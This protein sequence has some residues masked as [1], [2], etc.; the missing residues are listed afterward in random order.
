[1]LEKRWK[2]LE[3][4]AREELE[5]L[6]RAEG[7]DMKDLLVRRGGVSGREQSGKS[8]KKSKK[9]AR[10]A[11]KHTSHPNYMCDHCK[12]K[13]CI[14]GVRYSCKVGAGVVCE[15]QEC[16]DYD[17]CEACFAHAAEFHPHRH[18]LAFDPPQPDVFGILREGK[19][20][21]VEV[22]EVKKEEK[23]EEENDEKEE[24]KKE[25]EEKEEKVEEKKEEMKEEKEEK[26]EED[27]SW[28]VVGEKKR[29][30]RSASVSEGKKER[31][32]EAKPA[33]KLDYRKA[34]LGSLP[35]KPAD[36]APSQPAQPAQPAQ[37]SQPAQPAQP[38]S[39]Q[40]SQPSQQSSQPAQQPSQPQQ[41]PQQPQQQ[42]QQPQQDETSPLAPLPLNSPAFEYGPVMEPNLPL[43]GAF[44]GLVMNPPENLGIDRFYD[45]PDDHMN[46][47][48][49]MEDQWWPK[50][51][52]GMWRQRKV[53][54]ERDP[55]LFEHNGGWNDYFENENQPM[56][57]RVPYTSEELQVS[58]LLGREG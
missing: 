48:A 49:N 45:Y 57:A 17:L 32:R 37:P 15:A 23:G 5:E 35:T 41:Q 4:N 43:G 52:Y 25:K 18:F 30:N 14:V 12:N 39:Q 56:P 28:T 7:Y 46:G 36:L 40:P 9:K 21:E 50:P 47:Y 31:R 38:S 29:R 22:K 42:P 8:H 44:S 33:S 24:E 20:R 55:W 26:A 3:N 2:E 1:M 10:V 16:E 51:E 11:E 19:G 53:S 27:S 13:R 6:L 34:V 58:E 54:I